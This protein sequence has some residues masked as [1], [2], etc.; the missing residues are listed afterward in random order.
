MADYGLYFDGVDDKVEVS[1]SDSLKVDDEVTILMMVKINEFDD[2]VQNL[3]TTNSYWGPIFSEIDTTGKFR[4]RVGTSS[5]YETLESNTALKRGK[6]YLLG[7]QA[8]NGQWLRLYVNG[9]EDAY[10]TITATWDP[11]DIEFWRFAYLLD[12]NALRGNIYLILIYNRALSDSEIQQIYENPTNPPTDGLVLFYA[13]DSVDTAN[14]IWTDKSGQGNDGT[15][16]GC[17]YIPTRWTTKDGVLTIEEIWELNTVRFNYP[18][19]ASIKNK[20]NRVVEVMP[21]LNNTYVV[22]DK[23]LGGEEVTFTFYLDPDY[24]DDEKI[25]S[26][27][28][29]SGIV[30]IRTPDL[31]YYGDYVVKNIDWDI[32]AFNKHILKMTAVRV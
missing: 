18:W 28:L 26:E 19:P 16:Y 29:S 10:E 6:I 17:L 4:I 27:I 12:D 14:D 11:V 24:D 1:A 23:A 31:R 20:I 7:M 5:T 3:F 8:K 2:N 15:I 13:P 22:F 21:T 32:D 25:R 9:I 30:K